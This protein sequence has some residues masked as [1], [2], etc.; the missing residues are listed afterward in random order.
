MI[1]QYLVST[2]LLWGRY[3]ILVYHEYQIYQMFLNPQVVLLP[4]YLYVLGG[5][6]EMENTTTIV[7]GGGDLPAG[8]QC[9]VVQVVPCTRMP[10]EGARGGLKSSMCLWIH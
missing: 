7:R 1:K 6:C 4:F 8:L 5:W 10:A 3:L 2:F 9:V